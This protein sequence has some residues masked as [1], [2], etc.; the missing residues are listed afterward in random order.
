[1]SI[2]QCLSLDECKVL[3]FKIQEIN[4]NYTLHFHSPSLS[5]SLSLSLSFH[6]DITVMVDW[7]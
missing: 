6:P 7:V 1:M 3:T 4:Q 2:Y 5:L